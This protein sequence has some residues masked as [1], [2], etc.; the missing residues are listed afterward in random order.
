MFYEFYVNISLVVVI[1]AGKTDK[2]DTAYQE[3][4]GIRSVR[5]SPDGRQ[6]ASG[7]RAGNVR[8]VANCFADQ[9]SPC[10]NFC[11]N[12]FS[13]IIFSKLFSS[14]ISFSIPCQ[15]RA[16]VYSFC[17]IQSYFDELVIIRK[18][19]ALQTHQKLF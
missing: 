2:T 19:H 4:N 12:Y 7:D 11:P 18:N 13:Q 5:F 8:L 10:W 3:K 15:T 6:L 9:F 16:F 17:L 14:V 1:Q